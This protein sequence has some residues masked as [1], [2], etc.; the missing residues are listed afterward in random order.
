MMDSVR[1]PAP[2]QKTSLIRV[3]LIEDDAVDRKSCIRALRRFTDCDY[4]IQEAD[5]GD[6]AFAL[7]GLETFDCALLDMRLPDTTGLEFLDQAED[8]QSRIPF[9]MMTGMDDLVTAVEAM[10]RGARDYIVKD[11]ERRYLDMLPAAI[12]RAVREQSLLDAVEDYRHHLEELDE[13]RTTELK[14]TTHKLRDEVRIRQLAEQNLRKEKEFA[15]V[16]LASIGDAVVSLDSEACIRYI[17]PAAEA[18]LNLPLEEA[19]GFPLDQVCNAYT[20]ADNAPVS[21]L[22]KQY[23]T[24]AKA[25]L[26]KC[27]AMVM[28]GNGLG[29]IPIELSVANFHDINGA[30]FGAVLVGRDN[31]EERNAAEKLRFQAHHDSLT[32][33]VNR[34]EL[35]HRLNKIIASNSDNHGTH[36]LCLIDLDRFKVVNDESGHAAGDELL[37][38][39]GDHLKSY[40]RQRDTLARV[41]GDEFAILLEHCPRD[42]AM[43]CAEELREAVESFRMPWHGRIHSVGAS[44][45]VVM[46]E[47]GQHSPTAL[48]EAADAACYHAKHSGR[49]CVHFYQPQHTESRPLE[50]GDNWAARLHNAL[51][52]NQLALE[53]QSF[54]PLCSTLGVVELMGGEVL[55]RMTDQHG[56]KVMPR[57]FIHHAERCEL[58]ARLDRWVIRHL[59]RQLG[60]QSTLDLAQMG[61]F[62]VNLCPASLHDPELPDFV[63]ECLDAH[64][65][66]PNC[67][68]FEIDEAVAT[69][70]LWA[71][72]RAFERLHNIGV[73]LALDNAQGLLTQLEQLRRLPLTMIKLHG[74]L[75]R[76]LASDPAAEVLV[77]AIN[78]MGQ[79]I[80]AVQTI[81]VHVETTDIIQHARTMGVNQAQGFAL[82]EPIALSS[83][84]AQAPGDPAKTLRDASG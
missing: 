82:H 22:V 73:Y 33:L 59:A 28:P 64:G 76:R 39:L 29:P 51:E 66:P 79:E 45:G 10:K 77:H 69:A 74:G 60:S 35:E 81:A 4:V 75:V 2:P 32:R 3:L 14:A 6:A 37:C 5:S 58:M 65:I 11:S 7:L 70:D 21:L 50:G 84:L 25:P 56:R 13:T 9:I 49:N 48:F 18:M 1:D 38:R 80:M 72:T 46:I 53:Y 43:I 62:W 40:M 78:R 20:E 42:K 31:S 12:T 23:M 83:Y 68:G 63:Q 16:T 55:L 30:V 57:A 67:I 34:R 54:S 8:L 44:I 17:N 19:A 26:F 36:A 47:H 71:T 15:Q 52:N 61:V 27:Q 24:Q 41:G